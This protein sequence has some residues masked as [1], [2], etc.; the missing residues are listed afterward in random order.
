MPE[1][2]KEI[3]RREL[4]ELKQNKIRVGI[5]AGCLVI[6]LIVSI[7]DDGERFTDKNF[8]RCE[9][10]RRRENNSGRDCRQIVYR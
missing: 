9:K 4:D 1:E 10:S 7:T 3:L 2:L 8:T 6:L 5:L